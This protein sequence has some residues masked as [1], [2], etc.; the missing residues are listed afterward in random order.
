MKLISLSIAWVVGIFLGSLVSPPLYVLMAASVLALMAAVMWRKKAVVLWGGLSLVI[1]LGGLAWYNSAVN[2]PSL[3]ACDGRIVVI[4]GEVVRDTQYGDGGAWFGFSAQ[5]LCLDGSCEQISGKVLVYTDS[6]PS[7]SQGDVLEIVG[8][9]EPLSEI[10]NSDYRTF[11]T[12]QGFVGTM[13][14]QSEIE[15]LHRSWLFSLRN[16]LAQSISSALPEPQASLAQGLLLGMRSHMPDELKDDFS[17]TGTSHLLAISGFNL[18]VIGGVI[19]GVAAWVF[20]RRRP[21]YLVVTV[22]MV[23][24]YSALTGMQPPVLRSAIMFTLLLVAL[25]L[26]RPGGALTALCF[27]GAI[28][29]GL[30]PLV[31]W[32][33]SFQLSFAAVAGLVL[34]QPSLQ[35]W[36]E[37]VIPEGHWVSSVVKPVFYSFAVGFAAIMATLPLMVYYFQSFSLVGLPATVVASVF[38]TG[39]TMLVGITALLG[40]FAPPLAWLVGWVASFFLMCIVA[41]VEWFARLPFASVE[42]GPINPGVVWAYYLLL[43]AILSRGRLKPMVNGMARLARRSSD[44]LKQAAWRL[45]KKR[46]AGVLVV[47]ASLIWVGFL[48]L[49]DTRLEVS[50]LDVGQGDA[51][52]VAGP[53]S[54]YVHIRTI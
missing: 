3:R 17:R 1:L 46:T 11:L 16:R 19:L 44:W 21:T 18:A 34:I 37:M 49:P 25:W 51:I 22:A 54:T 32:D 50:F 13:D 53:Q 27:A 36:G 47:C 10:S 52:L 35:E 12:R 30:D 33:V 4:E 2:E 29:V 6:F 40:L 24:L 20:G 15:V 8:E 9:I 38:V 39:A 41:T 31:L 42:T 48:N 26:G 5:R 45:P 23:W 14:D 43:M 7:Y 28:M